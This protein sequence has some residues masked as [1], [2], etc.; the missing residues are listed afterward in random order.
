MKEYQ[1]RTFGNVR[2]AI[3]Y[4]GHI[5]IAGDWSTNWGIIYSHQIQNFKDGIINPCTGFIVQVIGM[6]SSVATTHLNY[7]YSKIN[8]GYFDHL[9]EPLTEEN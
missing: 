7:I 4:D 9:I 5:S 6:D 8:K 2:V 3:D 1:A